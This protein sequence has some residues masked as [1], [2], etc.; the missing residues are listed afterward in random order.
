M[1]GVEESSPRSEGRHRDK[2]DRG[3]GSMLTWEIG[4]LNMGEGQ[5]GLCSFYPFLI[6]T[7]YMSATVLSTRNTAPDKA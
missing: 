1:A 4:N 2:K 5:S 7:Y 6:T 3:S